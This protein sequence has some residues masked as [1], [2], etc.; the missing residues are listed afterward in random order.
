MPR[1]RD[2][3]STID[4]CASLR[5]GCARFGRAGWRVTAHTHHPL[6]RLARSIE[7]RRGREDATSAFG[8]EE[9]RPDGSEQR[10]RSPPISAE[11]PLVT[12]ADRSAPR[13]HLAVVDRSCLR[14]TETCSVNAERAHELRPTFPVLVFGDPGRARDTSDRFASLEAVAC[15]V[16]DYVSVI[17]TRES[18]HAPTSPLVLARPAPRL[19][20]GV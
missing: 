20:G 8:S 18:E 11:R 17:Y 1:F 5:A 19:G 10:C 13:A 4:A 6:R 7:P 16:P 14:R 15:G 9:P 2:L 3:Q 12:S